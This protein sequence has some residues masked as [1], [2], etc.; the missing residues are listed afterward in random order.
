MPC[1]MPSQ[2]RKPD[3]D[4][5]DTR[6]I[7][8]EDLCL[9]L[10]SS[11][12]SSTITLP[13]FTQL[14]SLEFRLHVAQADDSL[15]DVCRNRRIT[16]SLYQFKKGNISGTGNKAN[17]RSHT[18]MTR[19]VEKSLAAADHYECA[20]KA[21]LALAPGGSWQTR[22]CP[23]N[24]ADIRGPGKDDEEFEGR[25]SE[26]HHEPSWIWMVPH[27]TANDDSLPDGAIASTADGLN[28][29]VRI[30]W[31]KARAQ[32]QRWHE[33]ELLVVEEMR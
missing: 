31:T 10:P 12:P 27:V 1:V 13:S 3:D 32:V 18:T 30:E 24:R 28:D 2:D 9:H 25:Q 11:L 15:E 29:D 26:G 22:L 5:T 14:V 20:R 7:H 23:L 19:F 17:T 8:A 6:S 16:Q 4:N 33:E 21:L